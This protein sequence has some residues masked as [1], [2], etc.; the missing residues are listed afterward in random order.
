MRTLAICN[1]CA[2]IHLWFCVY[3]YGMQC[4]VLK[5]MSLYQCFPQRQFQTGCLI[6]INYL[7]HEDY[8]IH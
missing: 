3:D 2:C 5:G 7:A 6:N 4:N 1:M 8:Y